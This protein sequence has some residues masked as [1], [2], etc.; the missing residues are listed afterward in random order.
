MTTE[1]AYAAA[2]LLRALQVADDC[3]GNDPMMR[4]CHKCWEGLMKSAG[5]LAET[6]E[7]GERPPYT[8]A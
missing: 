4:V 1:Q 2:A 8:M 7:P 6:L 5:A 3:K